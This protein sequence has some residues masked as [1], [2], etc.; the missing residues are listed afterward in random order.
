MDHTLPALIAKLLATTSRRIE[1][2]T[3]VAGLIASPLAIPHDA[4]AKRKKRKKRCQGGTKRCDKCCVSLT[5]DHANCGTCGVACL[6]FDA[7]LNGGCGRTC[8]TP[9]PPGG[10]SGA[11]CTGVQGSGNCDTTTEGQIVCIDLGPPCDTYER[12]DSSADC[13]IE[14]VCTVAGCCG[15]QGKPK[16]CTR[17]V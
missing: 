15:F 11:S 10:C 16:I 1:R 9:S 3:V 12:C 5:S 4:E 13:P 6:T 17:L 8:I 14:H 2:R 7:C